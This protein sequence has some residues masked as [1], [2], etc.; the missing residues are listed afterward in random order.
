MFT[1]ITKIK[2]IAMLYLNNMKNNRLMLWTTV[3][4]S[5]E[6]LTQTTWSFEQKI[7][8]GERRHPSITSSPTFRPPWPSKI[9]ELPNLPY[10][11][12]YIAQKFFP[13]P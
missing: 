12:C 3:R 11:P 7:I 2:T 9:S 10:Y 5:P 1:Y 8:T 6:N 13:P 4:Q